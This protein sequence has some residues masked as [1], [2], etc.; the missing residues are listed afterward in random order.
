M[1]TNLPDR[2]FRDKLKNVKMAI[3]KWS[4]ERFGTIAEEIP[5]VKK[6]CERLEALAESNTWNAVEKD[7]WIKARKRWLELEEKN[8]DG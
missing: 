6:E 2:V 1:L 4:K 3:K 5:C 7:S 8:R